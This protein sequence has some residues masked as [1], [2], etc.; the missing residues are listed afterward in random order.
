L[1]ALMKR[2]SY[3]AR[4]P[5]NVNANTAASTDVTRGSSPSRYSTSRSLSSQRAPPALTLATDFS[6][7]E[8][9]LT[10]CVDITPTG[11][12]ALKYR[13]FCP[14]CYR[15]FAE[16]YVTDCCRQNICYTCMALHMDT[17]MGG[18]HERTTVPCPSCNTDG[19]QFERVG[20]AVAT[21]IYDESPKT[22]GALQRAL[23]RQTP[24]DA[25]TRRFA[26]APSPSTPRALG[27]QRSDPA[28][29]H[30]FALDPLGLKRIHSIPEHTTDITTVTGEAMTQ[31]PSFGPTAL[32]YP[33]LF[34]F[35]NAIQVAAS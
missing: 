19:C 34:S 4:K 6:D 27:R 11:A 30:I 2:L 21:R 3:S 12:A 35:T 22:K 29:P 33:N 9:A 15:H 8:S 14:I 5:P 17:K 32:R 26:A 23:S 25:L 31:S 24:Q 28:S 1:T 20:G 16:I 7:V 18:E 13:H 10:D